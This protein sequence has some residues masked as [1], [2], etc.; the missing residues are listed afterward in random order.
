MHLYYHIHVYSSA[1]WQSLLQGEFNGL[2]TDNIWLGHFTEFENHLCKCS[3]LK[4]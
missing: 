3:L 2:K 4:E 1:T